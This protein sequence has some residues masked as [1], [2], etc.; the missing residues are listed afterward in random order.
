MLGIYRITIGNETYEYKNL[1]TDAGRLGLLRTIAGQ[2]NGWATSIGAGIGATAATTADTTLEFPVTGGDMSATIVD[3]VNEKIYFKSALPLNSQC[4]VYEL[5]C[6]STNVL[7]TRSSETG[8]G[9]LMVVFTSE[10]PWVDVE[11]T[12]VSDITNNR[13]GLDSLAYDI[14]S[15][16]TVKGYTSFI[17]DLSHIPNTATFKFAYYCNNIADLVLRFKTDDSNYFEENGWTVTNGYN[18]SSAAKSSFT[19]TG[20]P[21]W[22][23]IQTLEV[24]VDSTASAGTISLDALR[25][26]LPPGSESNLL[27]RVILTTPQDKFPGVPMDIEYMVEL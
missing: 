1:I 25:Y 24:E 17:N 4:R 20:N 8:G 6:H 12:V 10:L 13:V 7:S 22:S 3:P 23:D 15:S 14:P 21:S 27:S 11:G 18:I 19:V 2:R 26:D 5:G 9:N 16:D